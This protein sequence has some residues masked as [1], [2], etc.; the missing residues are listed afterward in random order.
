M[1]SLSSLELASELDPSLEATR[2]RWI[3]ASENKKNVYR[4]RVRRLDNYLNIIYK[5]VND[6]YDPADVTVCLTSD[7]GQSYL[8]ED[9][10]WL[11]EAR[12]KAMWL[13]KT[14]DRRGCSI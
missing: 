9:N 4:E 3:P 8:S 2:N 14:G 6:N 7:H 1:S 11:S 5:H 10:H 12:T 13:L